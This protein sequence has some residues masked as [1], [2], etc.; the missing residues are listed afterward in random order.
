MYVRMYVCMYVCVYIYIYIYMY[1]H[2]YIYVYVCIYIYIYTY[3]HICIYIYTYIYI[4]IWIYIYIYVCTHTFTYTCAHI[5]VML[6]I[7]HCFHHMR[8]MLGTMLNM[9]Y[10]DPACHVLAPG[11]PSMPWT[12]EVAILRAS[13]SVLGGQ[14]QVLP[15]S[16]WRHCRT[17]SF[18]LICQ[19]ARTHRFLS[20]EAFQAYGRRQRDERFLTFLGARWLLFFIHKRSC[21]ESEWL[22]EV[23]PP[24]AG[25]FPQQI[26]K[27]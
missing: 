7:L 24:A 4:C 27:L 14:P 26:Q 21:N 2:I 11:I 22:P 25:R 6:Y 18:L 20:K 19:T 17:L 13:T 1:I 12:C 3:K 10:A 8:R 23:A 15:L 5:Y 9:F 16:W